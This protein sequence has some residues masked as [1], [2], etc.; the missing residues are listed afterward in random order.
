MGGVIALLLFLSVKIIVG[1][2]WV[3]GTTE[4]QRGRCRRSS[5]TQ[6]CA[7]DRPCG[8][9][10]PTPAQQGHSKPTMPA[11][12]DGGWMAESVVWLLALRSLL[13]FVIHFC[14]ADLFFFVFSHFLI[15]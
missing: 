1:F 14:R 3:F 9:N 6:Q 11:A 5:E 7:G 8:G 13:C 2:V 15:R 10:A 12:P 4:G